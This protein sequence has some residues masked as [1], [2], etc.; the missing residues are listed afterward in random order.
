MTFYNML[1]TLLRPVRR[2]YF[3]NVN[4]KSLLDIGFEFRSCYTRRRVT[5][6]F[7]D[8]D[9]IMVEHECIASEDL[10]QNSK[11]YIDKEEDLVRQAL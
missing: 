4:D 3:T 7:A 8:G 6:V 10:K 11:R 5:D 2:S 1:E 9:D